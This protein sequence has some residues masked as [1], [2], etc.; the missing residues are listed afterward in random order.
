M[1]Q[2]STDE[3][4][5]DPEAS[6][7]AL[8]EIAK[9]LPERTRLRDLKQADIGPILLFWSAGANRSRL[10]AFSSSVRAAVKKITGKRWDGVLVH[11]QPGEQLGTM[12]LPQ[13]LALYEALTSAFHPDL[14]ETVQK[15]RQAAEARQKADQATADTMTAN[16][17]ADRLEALQKAAQLERGAELS[18]E[19]AGVSG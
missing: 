13:V 19:G 7:A 8:A 4:K 18:K 5:P 3:I 14:L 11:L 12:K 6:A 9:A 1:W 17:V 15:R 2:R 10:Q 16:A